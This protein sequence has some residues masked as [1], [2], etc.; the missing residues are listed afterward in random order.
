VRRVV[1]WTIIRDPRS[2]SVVRLPA[3]LRRGP[4][5]ARMKGMDVFQEIA[6]ERRAVAEMAEGLS[7]EQ[8][9]TRSLCGAWTVHDLLAHLLMPLETRP[10]RVFGALIR[11]RGDFDRANMIL[12]SRVS[13]RPTEELVAGLRARAE[14]RFT[15]P[16]LGPGAP[17]TEVLVHGLDMRRPLGI[18][19]EIPGERL[20]A[21]LDFLVSP[22]AKRG[23]V[24]KGRLDGL[25]LEAT[26]LDW[27]WGE[28]VLARGRA[29]SLLLA[30]TGRAYGARE[31]TGEGAALL[32]SRAPA[33][34]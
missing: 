15:P 6:A 4:P 17:L 33:E 21:S 24:A 8:L 18:P 5:R 16:G 34:R 12:T 3:E 13:S 26:D 11:A 31:L 9:A 20:R 27:S 23:F 2:P 22:R 28:G 29:E 32:L 7:A 10:P 14:S 1:E 19:R 25:R 30:L